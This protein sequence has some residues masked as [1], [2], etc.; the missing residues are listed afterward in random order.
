MNK[1]TVIVQHKI[2]MLI[3]GAFV[4]KSLPKNALIFAY[5]ALFQQSF[6]QTCTHISTFLAILV[7]CSKDKT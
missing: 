6:R 5:A 7:A 2:E 1:K 3:Y 4:T